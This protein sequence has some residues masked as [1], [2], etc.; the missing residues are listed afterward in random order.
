MRI[1]NIFLG[2]EVDVISTESVSFGQKSCQK[3]KVHG[4]ISAT[5]EVE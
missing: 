1:N 3:D 5:A 2:R 4:C